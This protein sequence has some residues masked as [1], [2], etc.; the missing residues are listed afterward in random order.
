MTANDDATRRFEVDASVGLPE[1]DLVTDVRE[2]ARWRAR[3]TVNA[4]VWRGVERVTAWF[5][6]LAIFGGSGLLVALL[7]V[8][9]VS[10]SPWLGALVVGITFGVAAAYV[11]ARRIAY[12]AELE[13][14]RAMRGVK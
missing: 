5:A 6:A 9:L 8:W 14:L 13:K 4:A 11:V 10:I 2:E 12:K 7:F 1:L 3:D